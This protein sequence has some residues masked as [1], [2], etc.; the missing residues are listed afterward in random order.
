MR[1]LETILKDFRFALRLMRRSPGLTAVVLSTL[2]VG[3][4]ATTAV[5]TIVHALLLRPLP[6][7][8]ADHLVM[9]WE[10]PP[11]T[12]HRNVT[13]MD[14]F[15]AW[16]ARSRSFDVMA[17]FHT[18]PLNL[19]GGDEPV[20]VTGAAVTA[21]FFRVLGT[22]PLLG[23]TFAPGEDAAG[24]APTV[25]LTHGFWQR[26][27]GG[28][29]DVIG[30]RI[31]VNVTHHEIIGVMPPGFAFPDR[32]VDVFVPLPV[33][34]SY[35]RNF[36]VVARLHRG[37]ALAAA[38]DEM[39]AI[40][41]HMADERPQ[42]NAQWSAT[43]IPLLEQTV[44]QIRRPLLVLFA[45]AGFVLLIA[46]ANIANLLLIR[47]TVR[48]RELSIR[49][50]L[51]AGQWRL[52]R[53]ILVE[54]LVLTCAGAAL[55]V[56]LAWWGV[57]ALGRLMPPTFYMPRLDEISVD[58]W[59]LLFAVTLT[60]G[61][62]LCF[63]VA[64]G[65]AVSRRQR[66]THA[67][68]SVTSDQQRVRRTMVI[69]EVALAFPLLVGATLMAQSFVR[70]SH[71][72]PGFRAEGVLAVRMLLLPVRE[73]SLH[74]EFVNEVLDRVRV[75]PG[76]VAAGSIGRLPLDGGNSGSWYYRA[77][78]PEP[79]PGDRPGGDISIITPGYFRAMGI[80][81]LKGRDFDA[82]DR[83]GSPHVAILNETAARAF[84]ETDA[85]IGK[86]L[87]VSWNDAREVEI[88]GIVADIR[89]GQIQS[90]PDPCLFMAN[91]QQPFPFSA[92][93]IRT[94][95]NPIALADAVKQEIRRVDSDQGVASIETM[96]QL[97][98][99]AIAQPRAQTLAFGAFGTLA[100][101]L[102]SIGIYGVLAYSVT[103]RKREMGL[104]IAL[105]ASPASAFRLVLFGG[106]RL[107]AP[108]LALGF[109]AALILTRFMRG[110]LYE[111][112]PL[113]PVLLAAAITML[114]LVSLA[115]CSVPALRATRVDPAIVLREE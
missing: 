33:N 20:Q 55:G 72:E 6:F 37:V 87:K 32:R 7:P 113:D 89:H 88:V 96:Q 59:V 102:A 29:T 30:R 75:L 18:T 98:D 3:I 8:D 28:R 93:V 51:G 99:Q 2:A 84:F 83:I 82:H 64:P 34:R 19:I 61:I 25:V 74:A 22:P 11:H 109:G 92:L 91:A 101:T 63:T 103:Q 106:L 62:A 112:E 81:V 47:S 45:A 15:L 5:F 85:A 12:D 53:Q 13:S 40:A 111:V 41:A 80:P 14:N 77:D 10:R 48:A 26:R 54:S 35:G 114:T 1:R 107:V 27:F 43:V 21:D 115:A 76:V 4:G 58:P 79:A 66:I 105:G 57:S 68:R 95:G 39:V 70:L 16:Q 90:K 73:P 104:R 100:L 36:S 86:R 67:G 49:L 69:A 31:S 44:G 94:L 38:R 78:R 50:A 108:G 17:A 42:M 56:G 23:R 110:L 52:V 60:I 24:A 71:V 65:L 97:V 9:I 46:C